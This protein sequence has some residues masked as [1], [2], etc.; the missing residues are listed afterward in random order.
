M[1]VPKAAV[2][3]CLGLFIFWNTASATEML[4]AEALQYYNEGVRMQQKG[5]YVAA[6]IAYRKFIMLSPKDMEHRKR[7]IN[8]IGVMYTRMGQI[9][10]AE[11]AFREVLQLQPDYMPAKLNLG[12]VYELKGQE[13]RAL[14]YWAR[15]FELDKMKPKDFVLSEDGKG[16][17]SASVHN[18]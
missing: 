5:N 9:D 16:P 14:Q 1:N 2:V 13:M 10:K 7:I 18:K 6:E 8:N 3:L 15:L 11:E 17:A 12:L 4:T